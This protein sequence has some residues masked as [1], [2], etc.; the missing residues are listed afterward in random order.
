MNIMP[1]DE[2]P[3]H[4][5]SKEE[6]NLSDCVLDYVERD[7]GCKMPWRTVGVNN[8]GTCNNSQEFINAYDF[9]K[10]SSD[11]DVYEKTGCYFMCSYMV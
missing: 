11:E 6:H 7:S 4:E 10:D 1:R 9:Y 2:L 3:C 5:G 8:A